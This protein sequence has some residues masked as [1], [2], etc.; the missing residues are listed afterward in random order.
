MNP[1]IGKSGKST[2][3]LEDE[4][5]L[6]GKGRFIDNLNFKGQAHMQIVR[7]YSANAKIN[8]KNSKEVKKMS[9]VLDIFTG[10]NLMQDK[11]LPIPI[12]LTFKRQNGRSALSDSYHALSQGT[13]RYVG[14]PLA[15]VVAE[16][17]EQALQAAESLEV[18]YEEYPAVTDLLEATKPETP[19][20]CC[21]LPDNIAAYETL[22]NKEELEEIF[23]N[24][25]HVTRMELI[26]NRLVGTPLEPRGLNCYRDPEDGTLILHASHQSAT[27]LHGFLCSIF[28]FQPE[29]LRVKVGDLGGGFGTKVAIYPEDV[30]VVYAA[31]KLKVPIKWTATRTEEFQASV[32]SR[33]HMNIA[34]LA[35]DPEGRILALSV[36]TLANTG[37]Y[38]TNPALLIPLG[39]M[40][41]VITSV[42][43]IPSIYLE[44]Q[45]VLTNT[46]P[47]GAY[48]GAGR[49]E[50]IY[51]MERLIDMTAREMGIDPVIMRKKNLIR[52]EQLPYTTPV[53]E[54]YD[55]GNF[56]EVFE[57]A[58]EIMDWD[59]FAVRRTLSE[60]RGM[61]RGR[62]LA[63][64]IEWTGGDLSET[65]RIE[66]DSDGIV[67]LFSG[68]QNMGQGLET[69]FTQL[70]SEKLQI[71]MKTVNI[72]LGDTK[73]VK[74]LGSFGS[75]SLFVGG[76]AILEGTKEFLK[77]GRE[78]AAEEL[79]A[80][81]DDVVY[82]NG[83]FHVKGTS[84][85]VGLFDLASKQS[86]KLIST[87]TE[88]TVEGRSW[89]NGCH[90]AEVEI[91]PETGSVFLA[92]YGSVDDTGKMINPM[93]VDGQIK[94]GI[95]QG[96]GQ[97]LLEQSV[98]DSDG[99]LL[100]ASFMDY[101]I[102]RADD[103]PEFQ[104]STFTDA[105]CLTNPLGAKGV[106]EIG[107]VGSIP[108]IA[109]AILDALWDQGVRK[110]DMPAYPQ[111]IW[112]LIQD[113]KN[114]R[115]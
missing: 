22:G 109:N 34:E 41:K 51:P 53:G 69:V 25:H 114:L 42:Y 91:D 88:K 106:G 49:P 48:R 111:K 80:A 16:S 95:A 103:L 96:A 38:L 81:E 5:L 40:S 74:G 35:C 21:D 28:K 29:Q 57:Q 71:P 97:V 7:S 46:A 2:H 44:T 105:P 43:E 32:H 61:L 20:L 4:R 89:P 60:K 78:L 14:Q 66:A 73:L 17:M 102:P 63:C 79:E 24:A 47:I 56:F 92:R 68:T 9:G 8:I 18:E 76:T 13:V 94:G 86:Q 67:T 6:K 11:I 33:D 112:K 104:S 72:V 12:T 58:I 59:G 93:I 84:I 99:Q 50:G 77:K 37:A 30:L 110:F 52:I 98:Y 70:L 36:K 85:G 55:S 107:T 65:V 19:L 15:I 31:K 115:K 82:Q 83:F 27:R 54:I 10:K 64:Y 62:G 100:T 45:C 23:S 87:E 1:L 26:N 39:L 113:A 101:A 3:R 90:I 75:R 108:T